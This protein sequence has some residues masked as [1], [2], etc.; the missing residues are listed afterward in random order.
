[1]IL[2]LF[3]RS[4]WSDREFLQGTS[5]LWP[6]LS[7]LDPETGPGGSISTELWEG[8]AVCKELMVH[9]WSVLGAGYS[10]CLL[11]PSS[12]PPRAKK[13]K[14]REVP[15]VLMHNHVSVQG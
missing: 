10:S 6:G 1:M 12:F 5:C 7:V 2:Y 15:R 11:W 14:E 3:A 13:D 8:T 4:N 9:C